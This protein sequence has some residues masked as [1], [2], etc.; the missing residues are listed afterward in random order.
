M[1]TSELFRV[2]DIRFSN[3]LTD[4]ACS[5]IVETWNQVQDMITVLKGLVIMKKGNP[6]LFE[7]I[8]KR[9]SEEVAS[10]ST[11]VSRCGAEPRV[12]AAL[13]DVD[14]RYEPHRASVRG[15]WLK[16]MSRKLYAS[17]KAE[18]ERR[19]LTASQRKNYLSLIDLYITNSSSSSSCAVSNKHSNSHVSS[20]A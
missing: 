9:I 6:L 2:F 18:I 19:S 10:L 12:G 15:D 17:V 13:G 3:N 16:L 7:F 5:V 14:D 8:Y 20:S 4:F 1:P 11:M